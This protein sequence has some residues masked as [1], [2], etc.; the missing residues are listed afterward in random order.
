[1]G[2]EVVKG[3]IKCVEFRPA[4]K[5][6][7]EIDQRGLLSIGLPQFNWFSDRLWQF[8]SLEFIYRKIMMC[9][10]CPIELSYICHVQYDSN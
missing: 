9:R 5:K 4:G 1:M 2:E 8:F 6:E 7:S 10:H 3:N